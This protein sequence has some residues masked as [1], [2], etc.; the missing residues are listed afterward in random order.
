MTPS[1]RMPIPPTQPSL[2]QQLPVVALLPSDEPVYNPSHLPGDDL[3]LAS[4]NYN[5]VTAR[6]SI[7]G[8]C[9]FSQLIFFFTWSNF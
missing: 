6:T 2:S 4:Y 8:E 5:P 1:V 9:F 7:F 3:F